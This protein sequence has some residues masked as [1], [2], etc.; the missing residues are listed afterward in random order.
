MPNILVRPDIHTATTYFIVKIEKV[1]YAK[2]IDELI[3]FVK[4]DL[5]INLVHKF[6]IPSTPS[7]KDHFFW[8]IFFEF[9]KF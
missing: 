1:S 7:S 3:L 8:E 6:M 2:S 9:S 4:F 5:Q